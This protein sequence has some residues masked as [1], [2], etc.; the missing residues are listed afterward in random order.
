M[1]K[2]RF[3]PSPTGDLHIGGART[4]LF[5]WLYARRHGGRF[6]LRIEDTDRQRSTPEAVRAI[7]DGMRWL[8]LDADE[9]PYYQSERLDRYR[10]AVEKLLAAGRAYPCYCSRERLE[11]LR[12]RQ[13]AAGEKPRY[14]GRCRDGAEPV[15]GIRPVVRFR[16]PREGK[17]VVDDL[18]HGRVVFDN[19][20]L[21]DLVLLREDGSPT[22]NLTVVVDDAEMGIT[23]VIRGDDH[24][25]NTPR[26]LNLFA[27]LG[28]TPPA[29]AHVPMILDAEGKKL[30]KRSGA[31][32]V[33]HYEAEGYL[34]EAMLNY[35][36]RLGWSHG[37]QEIFSREEMIRLFDLRQI[38]RAPA[39]L[40]PGKLLW[41]NEHYIKTLP[42]E[43]L[44]P[45]LVV[46]LGR[47]GVTVENGPPPAEVV[48]ALRERAKTLVEMAREAACFYREFEDY[49]ADA[50]RKQLRPA[51]AP[52]LAAL[53]ERL[54]GVTSWTAPVLKQVIE[55][56]AAA[57]GVGLGKV[58]QPL[59]VALTGRGASPSIDVTLA[60]VGRERALA[61]I[62]RAL[63]HIERRAQTS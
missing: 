45:R 6:V 32:S 49:D 20:E 38:H 23:H 46:Y 35:L 61:R 13:L 56:T 39:A 29:Y 31:A 60:L 58:G 33:M 48:E 9:G 16:N 41:L 11:A 5:A 2:T 7:L 47:I 12:A 52:V 42:A 1:V 59:R 28:L 25:N 27:A 10:A 15:P 37:D 55:D 36:V 24:L 4:A 53:R 51:A 57:L 43:V 8:G 50:A 63:R 21:D 40:N 22:Y 62:D 30:S 17:V 34:P 26:Q 19:A 54:A 3:A 18:V 44:A 14:D